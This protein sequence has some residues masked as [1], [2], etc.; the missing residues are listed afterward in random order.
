M[1]D[2]SMR[3]AI[4]A[5]NTLCL[6]TMRDVIVIGGGLAGLVNAIL[7]KR[8]GLDVVL[9]EKKRYPFHRVCG[10]YISNEV[11]PFLED[12]D[13]YPHELEPARIE[14]F[15]L[16]SVGGNQLHMDLDLG[17][18]GISRFAW[19]QWLVNKLRASGGEVREATE[20]KDVQWQ[21]DHFNCILQTGETLQ[22]KLVIGAFGKRSTLDKRMERPFMRERSPYVGVKYHVRTEMDEHTVALHN[23]YH[24]YC[25]I[26]KVEADRYNLCYL[27][28]RRNLKKFG[29]IAAMERAVLW[30]NP[31]LRAIFK[32]SDFLFDKPE[33]IN[34]IT[35]RRK[36]LV[37]GGVLMCG[38]AAGMITPLCG[39]GMGMAI[40][41]ARLLSQI[42]LEN[43]DGQAP[44]RSKITAN[45]DQVWRQQ[46]EKR[47]WAGR[48]IQ[49][50]F[51]HPVTS[52]MAVMAGKMIRPLAR[53]LMKQTHGE[54]F[55]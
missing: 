15:E 17:G 14:K 36:E 7:L 46:F 54:P 42:I 41:A 13:L 16:T 43:W 55:L 31:H 12:H 8:S 6:P 44:R 24:G 19:D 48:K 25:G 3:I 5:L 21:E 2:G 28:H 45:Y 23:F 26:N 20:V 1:Y 40:H 53:T 51:G 11:I 27:T 10:E 4:F 38:D 29:S 18:F 35:F 37:H 22:A 52:G 34:E 50:W 39:N 9:I 47:L 49:D 32:H 30:Q 33:V